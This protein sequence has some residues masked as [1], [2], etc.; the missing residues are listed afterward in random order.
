VLATPERALRELRAIDFGALLM[1]RLSPV[2]ETQE[3]ARR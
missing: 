1:D 2:L 3:T